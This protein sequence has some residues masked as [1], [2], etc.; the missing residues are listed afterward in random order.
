MQKIGSF[1]SSVNLPTILGVERLKE[2][3]WAKRI[4]ALQHF[5]SD[6]ERRDETCADMITDAKHFILWE[7]F[8]QNVKFKILHQAM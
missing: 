4:P 2:Y 5:V 1:Y 7:M 6:I 3:Q 8:V